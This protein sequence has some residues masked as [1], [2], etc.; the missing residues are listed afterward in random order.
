M[1]IEVDASQAL[2]GGVA[3]FGLPNTPASF[4]DSIRL[5]FG[6]ANLAE[7]VAAAKAGRG[8]KGDVK[9]T[10]YVEL[11]LPSMLGLPKGKA[12]VVL[13]LSV[14]ARLE[15][16]PQGLRLNLKN[17][18]GLGGVLVSQQ[19]WRGFGVAREPGYT[20][21]LFRTSID[22]AKKRLA[23][24]I[25]PL[26]GQADG[27]LKQLGKSAIEKRQTI[28][29]PFLQLN[30]YLYDTKLAEGA[31][32]IVNPLTARLVH[33]VAGARAR[34]TL[35]AG[36]L[37]AN[38]LNGLSDKP[39]LM[40][41]EPSTNLYAG[42]GYLTVGLPVGPSG[43]VIGPTF[44]FSGGITTVGDGKSELVLKGPLGGERRI[45]TRIL[46]QLMQPV[47]KSITGILNVFRPNIQQAIH[48]GRAGRVVKSPHAPVAPYN[49]KAPV[50]LNFG[51]SLF[52]RQQITTALLSGESPFA[53]IAH[54]MRTHEARR[55]QV[56]HHGNPLMAAIQPVVEMGVARG[57]IS[58]F[59]VQ[60]M[61]LRS[62]QAV[63]AA[64]LGEPDISSFEFQSRVKR[65]ANPITDWGS[66][67]LRIQAQTGGE[68]FGQL[69]TPEAQLWRDVLG[70]HYRPAQYMRAPQL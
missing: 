61:N 17:I 30:G 13:Q 16:S 12:D 62:A 6:L 42:S 41:G 23:W 5:T 9:G 34:A 45:D 7:M 68:G 32:Q 40:G 67:A 59:E 29:T 24:G 39:K 55:V 11:T 22:P 66:I 20:G 53:L 18:Q 49:T 25:T 50:P 4:V 15:S 2:V 60:K 63:V 64:L 1:S 14:T 26:G 19:S 48:E 43:L 46:N 21:L 52:A 69:P 58:P 38:L 31:G 56:F 35:N 10:L 37:G 70:G 44:G 47:V 3:A 8:M 57:L 54:T 33:E 27:F 51:V 28:S 36:R 65:L